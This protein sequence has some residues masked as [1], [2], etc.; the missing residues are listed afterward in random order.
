MPAQPLA[1][2]RILQLVENP[3]ASLAELV[4][5]V[6]MDPALSARVMRMA[7]SRPYGTLSVRSASRAVVLLGFDTVKAISAAAACGLLAENV[8]LGPRDFWSHSV[9]VA[10]GASVA[11]GL[12]GVTQRDAFSTGLQH[13]L[14]AALLH[15]CDPDAYDAIVASTPAAQLLG[16]ERDRF[17]ID[18]AQAGAAALETWQFPKILVQA[19]RTHHD[20]LDS[21]NRLAQT[22]ILG[23]AVAE[24][25]DPSERPDD[26]RSLEM[27]LDQL[28]LPLS[29]R[30]ELLAK[31]RVDLDRISRYM[32]V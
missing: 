22:V 5:V 10:A 24:R 16:A 17:D 20:P 19:V 2:M 1:A 28:G 21:V 14:G 7:N 11:A 8:N 4:R 32:E 13:D 9:S 23:H 3:D 15:R 31:T 18:H 6:D 12:L 27:I 26:D 30:R 29:T 25:I